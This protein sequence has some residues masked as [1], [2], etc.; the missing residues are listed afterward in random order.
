[1]SGVS[2]PVG[3]HCVLVVDDEASIR[4]LV[5]TI[6]S[7]AGF[8]VVEA[9]CGHNAWVLLERQLADDKLDL[10]VTDI[11]MDGLDGLALAERCLSEYPRMRVLLMSGYADTAA[12][13]LESNGRW[14]FLL[15]PFSPQRLL[16]AIETL[17]PATA[18]GQAAL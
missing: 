3:R 15:K 17:R 9:D 4:S 11:Q 2:Q 14:L 12:L 10:V 13:N 6:L 16:N 18:R 5:R 8:E 7:K 1:M